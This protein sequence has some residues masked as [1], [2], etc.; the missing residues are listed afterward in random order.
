MEDILEL[1][2]EMVLGVLSGLRYKHPRT[3]TWVITVFFLVLGGALLG[4]MAW[5]LWFEIGGIL[6][7]IL[8]AA[9]VA[10]G[11]VILILGHRKNWPSGWV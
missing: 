3:R 9:L 2:A 8:A 1:I 5:L 10:G 4:Y 6:C 7:K 11:A